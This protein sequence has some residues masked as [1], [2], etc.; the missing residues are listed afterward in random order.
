MT[1]YRSVLKLLLS[2]LSL[3]FAQPVLAIVDPP[4][5][6]P[7]NPIAGEFVS[8][9]IRGGTCDAIA[10]REGYPQITQEGNSIRILEYGSHYEP[11]DELCI[12][13][14]GTVVVPLGVFPPGSISILSLGR[15]PF[16]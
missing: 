3:C 12:Y 1:I 14:T 15:Q 6:T 5:I 7:A 2:L 16:T 9:N 10:E 11:G 8:V 13:G 4:W